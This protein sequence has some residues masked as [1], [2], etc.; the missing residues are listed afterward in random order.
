MAKEMQAE[1][2]MHEGFFPETFRVVLA[3]PCSFFLL[4]FVCSL[5]KNHSLVMQLI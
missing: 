2:K 3:W 4:L 5:V 1:H